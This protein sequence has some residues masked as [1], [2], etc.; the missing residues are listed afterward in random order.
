MPKINLKTIQQIW[1]VL[2]MRDWG[3]VLF[4]SALTSTVLFSLSFLPIPDINAKVGKILFGVMMGLFWFFTIIVYLSNIDDLKKK[5]GDLSVQLAAIPKS[6]FN[7]Y[8]STRDEFDK[9]VGMVLKS[10]PVLANSYKVTSLNNDDKGSRLAKLK[11]IIE[12]LG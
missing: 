6:D 11:E 1:G 7:R 12:N 2:A 10:L 3:K 9:R 5:L 4:I 8:K